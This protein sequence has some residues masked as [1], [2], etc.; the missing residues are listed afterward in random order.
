MVLKTTEATQGRGGPF[1]SVSAVRPQ[2]AIIGFLLSSPVHSRPLRRRALC[3]GCELAVGQA[4]LRSPAANLDSLDGLVA[5][6]LALLTGGTGR[7]GVVRGLA[8]HSTPTLSVVSGS[9]CLV[10]LVDPL[11]IFDKHF[12]VLFALQLGIHFALS[13][14]VFE[15]VEPVYVAD[16]GRNEALQLRVLLQ[17]PSRANVLAAVGAGTLE[18]AVVVVD[19]VEAKLVLAHLHFLG[20]PVHLGADAA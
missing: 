7:F 10:L 5:L 4:V 9:L 2:I 13:D 1:L 17:V 20:I 11:A 19:A 18:R 14:L 12:F 15:L 6:F 3:F 8:H 16:D